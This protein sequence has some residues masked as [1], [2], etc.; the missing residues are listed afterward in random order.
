ME[1]LQRLFGFDKKVTTVRTEITA[2][3]T[4][5]LAMA[6]IL[7]VNPNQIFY[8]GSADARWSSLC[9]ATALGAV[10]GTLLMAMIAKMPLAQA[11]GMGLNSLVGGI[12]G[13]GLGYYAYGFEFTVGQA[14]MM[15]LISGIIFLALST[16]KIAGKSIRE[17]IFDG[18]RSIQDVLL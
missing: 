9:I 7:T 2:G 10:I 3:I 17:M 12:I 1:M 8:D 5:F 13:G 11:S 16:I 4:T 6:Y 15:V 14:F 18:T